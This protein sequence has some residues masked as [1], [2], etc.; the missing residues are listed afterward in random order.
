MC[1]TSESDAA[2][3]FVEWPDETKTE[4]QITKQEDN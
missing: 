2:F 1:T 3:E 4:A